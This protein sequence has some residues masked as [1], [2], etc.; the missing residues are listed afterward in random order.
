MST[1]TLQDGEVYQNL[2]G[3]MV[4][5][6]ILSGDK[7]LTEEISW[8]LSMYLSILGYHEFK[9]SERGD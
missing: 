3:L 5:C 6:N 1:E 4:F 7:P 2:R 8:E 9:K